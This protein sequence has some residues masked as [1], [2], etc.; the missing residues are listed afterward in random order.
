[1]ATYMDYTDYYN[2]LN[3]TDNETYEIDPDDC[4]SSHLYG[5]NVYLPL[6]Y[7]FI[8]LTGFFGNLFVITV[9]GSRGKRGGR[10]VDTFVVNLAVA[11]LVFVF[12]LPLWVVS[13]SQNGQWNFGHF[14]DLLCKV[15]SYIITVNRFSNIFFLTCMSVDRYLAVVKLMDSRYLR[16][17]GCIRGTCTAVWSISLMLGIPSLLYRKVEQSSNGQSCVDDEQSLVFLSLSLTMALLTFVLPVLIILFCY[18]T[19]LTHLNKHCI[20][21]ANHRAKARHRHSLKMV[22]SIIV[23]FVVS[24]LPFNI[25][26]VII[27][28]LQLSGSE[29]SCLSWPRNGLVLSC[30]LAFLNSCVNPAIYLL[31]DHHFRR[32]AEVIYT[33]WTSSCTGK[34]NLHSHN[35]SAS[36]TNAAT[37]ES[38][39]TA[40]GRSQPQV[41]D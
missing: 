22:V 40:P 2:I 19:I 6:V 23:A 21:A 12:T 18:G 36:F 7:S 15:S 17:S 1:M 26:K 41:S 27:I 25:F 37:S 8:F 4:A 11:D 30:C 35:S 20:A 10:L 31:L 9:M 28:S 5:S 29:L 14:G 32:Q 24:W 16:S 13:E 34:Q 38:F 33:S 39:A 3:M